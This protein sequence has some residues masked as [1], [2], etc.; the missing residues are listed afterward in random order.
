MKRALLAAC[1][2]AVLGACAG[3]N[4]P[5]PPE[6]PAP[7]PPVG[8]APPFRPA[9]FAW[10]AERGTAVIRGAVE[11]GSGYSCAGQPVVLVPD[12]PFSRW[13][14]SQFYGS[15]D[16]AALPVAEVRSRQANRPSDDYSA[17]SKHT[18][19][20]A[21]GHFMFQGLPTGSWYV[22]AVTRPTGGQGQDMAVMRRVET[23]PS[24]V[25]SVVLD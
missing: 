25:R 24:Q 17:F 14:I 16:H 8:H 21:Q 23:R 12:A 7:P 18:A 10:S 20:D 1:L 3:E 13:R 9:D 22:I 15:D 2:C 4:G 5:P 19:C 6:A 11:Y